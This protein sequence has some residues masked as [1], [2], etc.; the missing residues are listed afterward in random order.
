LSLTGRDNDIDDVHTVIT[1]TDSGSGSATAVWDASA[2]DWVA[3][4]TGLVGTL[5]ASVDVEDFA[6]NTANASVDYAPPAIGGFIS[7]SGMGKN[8]VWLDTNKDGIFDA[9]EIELFVGEDGALHYDSTTGSSVDF[10][11]GDWKVEFWDTFGPQVNLSGFGSGDEAIINMSLVQ[12]TSSA[13]VMGHRFYT[14]PT[15]ALSGSIVNASVPHT[16]IAKYGA[17]FNGVSGSGSNTMVTVK[18]SVN[19]GILWN[20]FRGASTN[21][22][23]FDTNHL[24]FLGSAANS[25]YLANN[26]GNGASLTFI[27][28]NYAWAQT[29][30]D[31]YPISPA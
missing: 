29:N 4:V 8:P 15:H 18:T 6:G 13:Y 16:P 25:G 26:F 20:L 1:I 28:P 14:F 11:V 17:V 5:T 3:D 30:Y 10:T 19:G 24:Y 31:I 9:D 27:L 12:G 22:P 21:R 7:V 2:G 23:I